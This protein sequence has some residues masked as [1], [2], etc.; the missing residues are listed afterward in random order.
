MMPAGEL[1]KQGMVAWTTTWQAVKPLGIWEGNWDLGRQ[2][3]GD[4]D[5]T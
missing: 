1:W 4:L 2:L 3:K 5:A